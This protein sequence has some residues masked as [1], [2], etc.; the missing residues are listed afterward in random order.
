M[1][2]FRENYRRGERIQRTGRQ[3]GRTQTERV[4]KVERRET[5][6][7]TKMKYDLTQRHEKKL[8]EAKVGRDRQGGQGE[9]SGRGTGEVERK[10]SQD[11]GEN[12]L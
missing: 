6:F 4:R 9:L 5:E 8:R 7:K 2:P 3:Q 1:K 11:T 10:R 12:K